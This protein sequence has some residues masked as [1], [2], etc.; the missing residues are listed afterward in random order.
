MKTFHFPIRVIVAASAARPDG[1]VDAVLSAGTVT[2]AGDA[3]VVSLTED[4]YADI[5]RRFSG[6][7]SEQIAATMQGLPPI[8]GGPGAELKKLLKRFGIESTPACKCNAMARQM[9]AWGTEEF[10]KPERIE[11]VLAVMRAEAAKRK[12]PFLD[13]VGRMLI[14][15]AIANAR[16]AS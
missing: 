9:D 15:R 11:E 12:L 1:Y 16:R 13:A 8:F 4:A 5:A 2:G 14:R 10:S 7:T 3:R 6:K